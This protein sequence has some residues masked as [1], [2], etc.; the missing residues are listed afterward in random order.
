MLSRRIMRSVLTGRSDDADHSHRRH[1]AGGNSN[2]VALRRLLTTLRPLGAPSIC[3]ALPARSQQEAAQASGSDATAHNNTSAHLV[4]TGVM[5]EILLRLL[6]LQKT[7]YLAANRIA[8]LLMVFACTA[9]THDLCWERATPVALFLGA[10]TPHERHWSAALPAMNLAR[11][12]F[13]LL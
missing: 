8:T 13:I 5:E 2:P 12:D 1:C 10:A 3:G 9:G 6:T 11:P 4:N 7:P